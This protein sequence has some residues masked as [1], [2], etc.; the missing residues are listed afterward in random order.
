MAKGM[1]P[2]IAL[3]S[4]YKAL[5]YSVTSQAVVLSYMDVFYYLGILFL[6]AIPFVLFVKRNKQKVDLSEAMH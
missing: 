1:T 6:V 4:A 2:D 3:Q 5:D